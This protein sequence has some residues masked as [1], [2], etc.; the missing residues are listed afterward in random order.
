MLVETSVPVDLHQTLAPFRHGPHDPAFRTVDGV[1][2][3][4]TR[5][6]GGAATLRLEQCG[7]DRVRVDAWGPGAAEALAAAPALLGEGDD[8]SGF[9][10]P[11]GVVRE[12]Y[13]RTAGARIARSG[14]VLES[15]VPVVL[16][17]RVISSTAHEAWR[18]LL[19]RHG[20]VAPGP[21][22][23]G[24]RVPP[25][26]GVWGQV[27]TWDFHLAGVDPGRARTVT[28]A[29]RLAPQLERAATLPPT[30]AMGLLRRVPGV[31]PWTAANVAQRAFGDPDA[32]HV[33]DFHLPAQVGWALA[34]RRTDDAGMLALLEPYRG[35][36]WRVVKHLLLSGAARAPRRGPR[37][38]VEDHRGR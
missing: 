35:H 31:G 6:A 9:V 30:H 32:V 33:G 37:L 28:T 22:P 25:P 17:Q 16:E 34:G 4:A 5:R 12:A 14:L 29:A 8:R 38:A 26:P 21:A 27:P 15:L 11:A 20:E 19:A 3:R 18:W 13:R 2:W 36:R 24:M 7:R 1:V 10:P 23:D